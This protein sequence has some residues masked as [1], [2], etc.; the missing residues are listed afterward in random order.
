M[1]RIK[2]RGERVE[3]QCAGLRSRDHH[4]SAGFEVGRAQCVI[5]RGGAGLSL[6][7]SLELIPEGGAGLS[8]KAEAPGGI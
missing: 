1:N 8:E 4:G 5:T 2:N 6:E 7:G 3:T